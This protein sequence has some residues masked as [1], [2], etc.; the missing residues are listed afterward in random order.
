VQEFEEAFDGL[1]R[2]AYRVA[3]RLVGERA[4]AE[5]VAQEAVA[6]ACARWRRVEDHAEAWVSRVSTNLAV[7]VWRRGQRQGLLPA[8]PSPELD[9][10]TAD[11]LDLHEALRTLPKRQREV[12]ALRYLADM[13]EE[14]VAR[15][16][17]CSTGTV[18]QHA[19]RGLTA[20]RRV[21]PNGHAHV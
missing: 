8:K 3:Y 12:V 7:D 17:G 20:L 2:L 6:R 9:R 1:Y 10:D 14:S 13:P 15:A 4:T 21:I 18:K 5:D 16:L 19:S 11:R